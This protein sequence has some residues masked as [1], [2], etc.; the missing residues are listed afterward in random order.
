MPRVIPDGLCADIE[1]NWPL[2][3]IF[4]WIMDTTQADQDEMLRVFNCGIGMVLIVS[5]DNL[6]IVCEKLT[7][8]HIIGK[9]VKSKIEE[10][11]RIRGNIR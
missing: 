10:K 2:P 4:S 5:P 9:I 8:Y 11:I 1:I 3:D 7:G 6:S